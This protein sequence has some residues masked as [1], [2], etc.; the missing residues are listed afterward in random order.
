MKV[1]KTNADIGSIRI[2]NETMVLYFAN[3]LG[4][5][6]SK[7]VICENDS[8][9]EQ[10][11]VW[12]ELEPVGKMVASNLFDVKTKAYLSDYDCEEQPIYE[13]KIGTYFVTLYK[14]ATF[15][16]QW[17]KIRVKGL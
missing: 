4:D 15:L 8:Q 14:D 11:A 7:V 10:E 1:L 3:G 16:I 9:Q 12:K 6:P 2:Y 17:A 13:F 5:M